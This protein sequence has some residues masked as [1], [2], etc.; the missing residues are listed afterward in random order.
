M[1]LHEVH[2]VLRDAD[3]DNWHRVGGVSAVFL[4]TF[5]VWTSGH[6]EGEKWGLEVEGHTDRAVYR[7]DVCLGLAW[8]LRAYVGGGLG[9]V[10]RPLDTRLLGRCSVRRNAH[11]PLAPA[12]R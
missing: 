10:P 2:A 8:G 7:D 11:R 9:E 4:D 12:V 3:I 6:G 1:R 5:G